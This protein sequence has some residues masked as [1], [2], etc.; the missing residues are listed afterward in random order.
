MAEIIQM[1]PEQLARLSSSAAESEPKKRDTVLLSL[2]VLSA[3]ASITA[4]AVGTY[5]FLLPIL[6]NLPHPDNF[7]SIAW[8]FVVFG[9]R[10]Y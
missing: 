4:V 5:S 6:P 7:I 10:S 1:N 3:L 8:P 9:K 2:F